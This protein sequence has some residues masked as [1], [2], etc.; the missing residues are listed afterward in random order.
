MCG[1]D[2]CVECIVST[3]KFLRKFD[4]LLS[5]NSDVWPSGVT[6]TAITIVVRLL[7]EMSIGSKCIDYVDSRRR[8]RLWTKQFCSYIL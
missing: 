6:T 1:E 4:G 5:T 7:R 2:V 8:E 3:F